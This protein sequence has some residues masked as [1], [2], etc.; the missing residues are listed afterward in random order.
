MKKLHAFSAS[1][2]LLVTSCFLAVPIGFVVYVY[3]T[4]LHP[5]SEMATNC[6]QQLFVLWKH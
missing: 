4:F 6:F 1:E 5:S 2:K 3:I